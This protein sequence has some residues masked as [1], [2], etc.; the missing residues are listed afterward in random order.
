MQSTY[1]IMLTFDKRTV[2]TQLSDNLKEFVYYLKSEVVG[3]LQCRIKLE[4]NGAPIRNENEYAAIFTSGKPLPYSGRLT[5]VEY[6]PERDA[7]RQAINKCIEE[8]MAT[9][10]SNLQMKFMIKM[11]QIE[12][13]LALINQHLKSYQ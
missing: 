13:R 4:V 8:H 7:L 6:T 12:D 11:K 1:Q 3:D 5:V 9:I 10:Q 2:R